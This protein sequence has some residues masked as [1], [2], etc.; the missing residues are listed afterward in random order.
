MSQIGSNPDKGGASANE[1]FEE[2]SDL[3][4]FAKNP[5][6]VRRLINSL[7]YFYPTSVGKSMFSLDQQTV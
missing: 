7:G 3:E 1:I 5:G 4:E 2:F 6:F